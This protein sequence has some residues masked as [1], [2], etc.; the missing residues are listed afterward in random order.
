MGI[1]EE[2]LL[3]PWAKD[4]CAN[5]GGAHESSKDNHGD[6]ENRTNSSVVINK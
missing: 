6:A 4:V 1:S 3:S 5:D 2:F